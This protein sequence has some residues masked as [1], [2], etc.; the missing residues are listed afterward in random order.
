MVAY[1]EQKVV[2]NQAAGP[3]FMLKNFGYSDKQEIDLNAK[4][5][6]MPT[7]KR[8]GKDVYF[9]IGTSETSGSSGEAS[10]DS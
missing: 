3:I 8:D 4:V 10:Q 9:D 6:E 1:Y 5:V 2:G 7:I